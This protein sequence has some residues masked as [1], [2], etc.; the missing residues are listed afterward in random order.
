MKAFWIRLDTAQR[1][2]KAAM[3]LAWHAPRW[4]VRWCAIRLM[5]QDYGENPSD[6][7]CG[8][9]LKAWDKHENKG[10]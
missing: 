2:E 3:W 10:R 6:R 7:L 4:L 5:V 9:A 8:D 1:T